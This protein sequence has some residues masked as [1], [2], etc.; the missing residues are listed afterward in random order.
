MA[1]KIAIGNLRRANSLR[2]SR[3]RPGPHVGLPTWE[4]KFVL[5]RPSH[6]KDKKD[7][8]VLAADKKRN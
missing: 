2:P 5:Y 1:R 3:K 8:I 7:K 6:N 4:T